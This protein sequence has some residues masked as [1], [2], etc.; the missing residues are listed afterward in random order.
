MEPLIF[1]PVDGAWMEA[2]R[3]MGDG[4]IAAEA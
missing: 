4:S 2:A 3:P 1:R